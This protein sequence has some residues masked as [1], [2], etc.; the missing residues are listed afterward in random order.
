MEAEILLKRTAVFFLY[1]QSDQRKLLQVLR[2][3]AVLEKDC[4]EQLD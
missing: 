1:W 3:K 4:S 2:K